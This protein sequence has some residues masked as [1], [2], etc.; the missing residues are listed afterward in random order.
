MRRAGFLA[1]VAAVAVGL[2]TTAQGSGSGAAGSSSPTAKR[3]S[4]MLRDSVKTRGVFKHLHALQD[5]ADANGGNRATGLPGY[6]K[7]AAYVVRKLKRYGWRIELQRFAVDVFYQDEVSTLERTSPAPRAFAEETDFV[8]MEFSGSGEVTAEVVAVDLTIP[9]A[10]A[11][12]STSGCEASDFAG[13]DV[14]GKVALIQRGGCPFEVKVTN[15]ITAGAAAVVIFNEG[16]AGRTNALRATSEPVDGAVPALSASFAAGAE[17]AGG[18]LSGPTGTTVHI[19]TVT[20]TKLVQGENVIGELPGGDR[21]HVVMAGAHLDSVADGPGINDNGSGSAA[22]LEIARALSDSGIKPTNKVRFAW[23]AAEE[24]GLHGSTGYVVKLRER[25]KAALARIALYLNFDMVGSPNF[26]RMIYDGDG[27]TFGSVGPKGSG[28]IERTFE[29]YFE[30]QDLATGPTPFDGRSDYQEFIKAGIPAGGLYTGAEELKTEEQAAMYGGEA[31]VAFDPC[32]HLACDD[33]DN[34]SR[35]AIR[36]MV[37]AIAD[38]VAR[39]AIKLG[40]LGRK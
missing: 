27:S 14:A 22:L 18:V 15:A 10:P 35:R 3:F 9:P 37:P 12:S 19:R 4:A 13:L 20:H 7:S 8:T 39:Y 40:K 25:P 36:Q 2:I 6:T 21:N 24:T 23:W 32:Y 26:G 34:V 29:R 1:L 5:I 33:I 30:G 16:Q 28:R 31:G 38:S 17:L 11:P